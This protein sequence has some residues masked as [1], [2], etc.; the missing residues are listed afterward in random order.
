M[1]G[2]EKYAVSDTVGGFLTMKKSPSYITFIEGGIGTGAGAGGSDDWWK[3]T[4]S[5]R[6]GGGRV[7]VW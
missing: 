7:R 2:R 4:Y 3:G 6:I 1:P 5:S